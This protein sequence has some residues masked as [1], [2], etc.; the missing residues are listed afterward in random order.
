MDSESGE[1]LIDSLAAEGKKARVGQDGR[2][3]TPEEVVS[4]AAYRRN[5]RAEGCM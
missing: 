1:Q 2:I 3:L 5:R 4:P